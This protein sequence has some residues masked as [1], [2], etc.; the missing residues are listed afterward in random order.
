MSTRI[1]VGMLLPGETGEL[2]KSNHSNKNMGLSGFFGI[3]NNF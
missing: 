2:K 1:S 3:E